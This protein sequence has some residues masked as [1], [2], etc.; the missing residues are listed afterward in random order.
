MLADWAVW[1]FVVVALIGL[2]AGTLGGM[3][4]V[5]G[6]VIMIPALTLVFGRE[7]HL[8]QA[9]AMAVNVC[10]AVPAALRHRKA[11]AVQR[12]V[13]K[14]LLPGA[15]VFVLVGVALS[16]APWFAGEAGGVWLGRLLALFLIY[17]VWV[18]VGRLRRE[19]S[20]NREPRTVSADEPRAPTTAKSATPPRCLAVGGVMGTIAG[21]LGIGGGAIAVPLQ[22]T[23]LKLPL[24]NAIANSTAVISV[25]AAIGAAVKLATLD[26]HGT[27]A[28]PLT[29]QD[30]LLLAACLAPTAFLGG[31]LGASLTHALPIRWVRLAFVVLMVVAA[32]RMAI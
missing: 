22:Q 23:V 20:N 4:G 18:N 13:L 8:Y 24:R 16:N 6:S 10:V 21:L 32:A 28:Q 2:M 30:G 26:Q 17:V 12:D 7:Q 14:W 3:L 15:V 27:T 25:S 29:W 5:G 9:A 11:G 1:Q 31:R 19:F